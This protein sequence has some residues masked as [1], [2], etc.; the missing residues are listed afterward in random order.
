MA[1]DP[2]VDQE[3][4]RVF[5]I[6]A[7]FLGDGDE[8]SVGDADRGRL[9]YRAEVQGQPATPW[10][11][12]AGRVEEEH[13][14]EPGQPADSL[15]KKGAPD[16]SEET[17][18]VGRAGAASDDRVVNDIAALHVHRGRPHV[19]PDGASFRVT[20]TGRCEHTADDWR[21]ISRPPRWL[22]RGEVG[23]C[24]LKAFEVRIVAPPSH[25][26]SIIR[27]ESRSVPRM[28]RL[29]GYRFGHLLVDGEEQVRDVIVLP[30]R[31]VTNWRRREGH[32]LVVEDLEEVLDEIPKRLI[33]G[34]G[35]DGRMQPD[36]SC[37]EEL[38]RRGVE[39]EVAPTGDAVRRYEVLDPAVTAAALHL[40]C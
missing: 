22:L 4:A 18:A 8:R 36:P 9:Q 10:M 31:V 1:H 17:G 7:G 40:T 3:L 11:I 25:R 6:R 38:R 14:R 39:V 15:L 35:H 28:A 5:P 12:P 24:D 30:S 29:E 13:V 37:M 27:P 20:G 19:L 21:R 23:K 2:S 16:E 34:T 33:V 32:A 26:D